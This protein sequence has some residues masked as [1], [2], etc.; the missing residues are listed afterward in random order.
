MGAC[1]RMPVYLI[2]DKTVYK[3]FEITPF[4][5]IMTAEAAN[6]HK[7][8]SCGRT[9]LQVADGEGHVGV[10]ALLRENGAA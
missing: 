9:A 8:D 2:F 1:Q 7:V 4:C 3:R 10:S 5:A 6:D